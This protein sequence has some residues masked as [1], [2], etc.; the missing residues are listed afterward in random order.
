MCADASPS[1][2]CA[3]CTKPRGRYKTSPG[4]SVAASTGSPIAECGRSG[5]L[6]LG[7]A[8]PC[9]GAYTFQ[10]FRPAHASQRARAQVECQFRSCDN[11]ACRATTDGVRT[12]AAWQRHASFSAADACAPTYCPYRVSCCGAHRT[13]GTQRARRRRGAARG[14]AWRAA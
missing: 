1:A 11:A 10:C 5:L 4:C 13:S 6:W 8:R 3:S 7:S 14:L 2:A 12:R 9:S